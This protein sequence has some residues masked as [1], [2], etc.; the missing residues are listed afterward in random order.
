MALRRCHE[1]NPG[2]YYHSFI[3]CIII[4]LQPLHLPGKSS[5]ASHRA[6]R[7][8]LNESCREPSPHRSSRRSL[9]VQFHG[10]GIHQSRLMYRFYCFAFVAFFPNSTSHHTICREIVGFKII[11]KVFPFYYFLWHTGHKK[12]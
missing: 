3:V 6:S 10:L 8:S 7:R 11:T 9:T 4:I 12:S 1:K 2:C 5:P